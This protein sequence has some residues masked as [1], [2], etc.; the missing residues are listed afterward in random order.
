[1]V[2]LDCPLEDGLYKVSFYRESVTPVSF[3]TQGGGN[4]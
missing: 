3:M 4:Q 2:V 1:M